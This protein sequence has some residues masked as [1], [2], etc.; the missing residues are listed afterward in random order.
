VKGSS[1]AGT[2]GFTGDTGGLGWTAGV[3][4]MGLVDA[5]VSFE[6]GFGAGLG[7]FLMRPR[8]VPLVEV[9]TVGFWLWCSL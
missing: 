1:F 5:G 9:V 6:A 8:A 2:S 7:F 3:L 4:A